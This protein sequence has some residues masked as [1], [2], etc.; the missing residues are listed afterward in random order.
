[1]EACRTFHCN[2][3]KEEERIDTILK[4]IT[5][6][7]THSIKSLKNSKTHPIQLPSNQGNDS[8]SYIPDHKPEKLPTYSKTPKSK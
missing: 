6:H 1:M 7:L 4:T 5:T 2:S 8:F 3:R